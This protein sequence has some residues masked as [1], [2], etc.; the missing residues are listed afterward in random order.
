VEVAATATVT[1]NDFALQIVGSPED[2]KYLHLDEITMYLLVPS[3]DSSTRLVLDPD[4]SFIRYPPLDAS[5][6]QFPLFDTGAG[7]SDSYASPDNLWN[8]P[9]L[10]NNDVIDAVEELYGIF[11]DLVPSCDGSDGF[12]RCSHPFNATDFRSQFMWCNITDGSDSLSLISLT[13][14]GDPNCNEDVLLR[15]IP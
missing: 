5:L 6:F 12:L 8:L 15:I 10:F 9:I 4:T 14:P 3:F 2:G 13:V 11:N 1:L 7:A